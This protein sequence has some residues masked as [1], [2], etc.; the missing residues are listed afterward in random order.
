[1]EL[2]IGEWANIYSK[3]INKLSKDF[4]DFYLDVKEI[5]THPFVVVICAKKLD[6]SCIT[7]AVPLEVLPSDIKNYKLTRSEVLKMLNS[8]H[9]ICKGLETNLEENAPYY[10][11]VRDFNY[12]K[13]KVNIDV[14]SR[15]KEALPFVSNDGLRPTLTGIYIE[16]Q[17]ITSTDGKQLYNC[18]TNTGIKD[19]FI[20]D[21]SLLKTFILAVEVLKNTLS[22]DVISKVGKLVV[23]QHGNLAYISREIDGNY[24]DYRQIIPEYSPNT[25]TFEGTKKMETFL[26]GVTVF[27]SNGFTELSVKEG[28]VG[29]TY[30]GDIKATTEVKGALTGEGNLIAFGNKLLLKTIKLFGDVYLRMSFTQDNRAV[31]FSVA[32]D[33]NVI[34]LQIPEKTY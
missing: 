24:P 17:C 28:S 22:S 33:P 15:F 14:M 34:L 9:Y 11:E 20:L 18:K 29:L 10:L 13:P 7:I 2:H 4:T 25:F 27:K 1:M 21:V 5:N 12:V 30:N 26:K 16:P 6:A 32:S 19:P 8:E 23:Y 3:S 31:I